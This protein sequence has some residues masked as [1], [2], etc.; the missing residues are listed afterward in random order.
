MVDAY[1]AYVNAYYTY[2][3]YLDAYWRWQRERLVAAQRFALVD[4]L[5]REVE[6]LGHAVAPAASRI[7]AAENVS[8]RVRMVRPN[9]FPPQS[10]LR[11]WKEFAFRSRSRA[12]SGALSGIS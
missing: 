4:G 5:P 10:R 11:I 12:S 3:Y 7:N 9:S 8:K 6:E 1:Y 2:R